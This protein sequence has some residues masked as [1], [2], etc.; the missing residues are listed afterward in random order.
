M[1][2][3]NSLMTMNLNENNQTLKKALPT[4][5]VHILPRPLRELIKEGY[6]NCGYP[7]A[8]TSAAMLAASGIAIG[9]FVQIFY[10]H[11]WTEAANIKC[12][13]IAS[14]GA[15]K[16]HS[17]KMIF[18]ILAARDKAAYKFY[19]K[20]LA[21]YAQR[22]AEAKA[23]KIP[24]T[25]P[26]PVCKRILVDNVTIEKL[27]DILNQNPH[28]LLMA[29]DEVRDYFIS[30]TRYDSDSKGFWLKAF[31]LTPIIIDRKGSGTTR[32]ENPFI[33]LFGGIQ[34]EIWERFVNNDLKECGLIDRILVVLLNDQI[35][36]ATG[37]IDPAKLI[38]WENIIKKLLELGEGKDEPVNIHLTVEARQTLEA[39]RENQIS[40]LN[41]DEAKRR[42]GGKWDN[43]ILRFALILHCLENLSNAT[44]KDVENN[45]MQKAI[46]LTS[47]FQAHYYSV[48]GEND[49]YFIRQLSE[50]QKSIYTSLPPGTFS[51]AQAVEV[52]ISKGLKERALKNWLNDRRLFKKIKYGFYERMLEI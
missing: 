15:G 34:P 16:S 14:K 44:I 2:I 19:C 11:T 43:Y 48:H 33:V 21:E 17:P 12:V 52:A 8:V 51:T 25:E 32:I 24:F 20:E 38:E 30:L 47:Y 1:T 50:L 29:M 4:F 27:A 6:M 22:E 18:K 9:N 28:G 36:Y 3:Q 10:K 31:N 26:E 5:P 42:M 41:K 40:E 37:D 35:R 45:T 13:M 46:E 23:A 39:W 7:E 49:H